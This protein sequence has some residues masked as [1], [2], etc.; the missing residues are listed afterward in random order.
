M[1]RR[2]MV[3][4]KQVRWIIGSFLLSLVLM[5][6]LDIPVSAEE[7]TARTPTENALQRGQEV[8]DKIASITRRAIY[9]LDSDQLMAVIENYLDENPQIKSLRI[10]ENVDQEVL[11]TFYRLDNRPIYNQPIPDVLLKLDV[12]FA[13]VSFEGEQIGTAEIHYADIPSATDTAVKKEDGTLSLS[14]DELTWIADHPVIR[15]HNEKNWAPFNFFEDN[16]PRGLSIDYMN[17]LAA[18]LGLKIVYQTGPSWNDFLQQIR[19]KQ[20]DVMLNIVKTEDRQEYVLFTEPYVKNPNVIVSR[21]DDP[22]KVIDTLK[23]RTVTFPKGFFYEEVLARQYPEIKRMPLED[24][25]ATLKAVALGKADA[26][27][28]EDAVMR[29]AISDNLLTNL[30][31][32]GEADIGNPDFANLRIGVRDDWQLLHSAIEKAMQAVTQ[33]EMSSIQQ[34]WLLKESARVDRSLDS[35]FSLFSLIIGCVV[36]LAVLILLLKLFRRLGYH[37]ESRLLDP[38]NL[39]FVGLVAVA[40]VLAVTF[41]VAWFAMDRMDRRLRTEMGETL[42]AVNRSARESMMMWQKSRMQE[43]KHL[44]RDREFLPLVR[45]LLVLPRDKERI[46]NSSELGQV[47]DF[48]QDYSR[49]M[50]AKGFFIITPDYTSIGSMRDA[51]I[52][53][54]NLI[55][56][57]QPTLLDR[58]FSGTTVF[59]PPTYSDVPLE[60]KS[61]GLVQRT[62]T[63]FFASP[64]R[65]EFG[66]IVAVLTLRFDPSDDLNR[67]TR[68]GNMGGSSETYAFDQ[69][70]RMLTESRLVGQLESVPGYFDGD[71]GLLSMR[72]RDPGGDVTGGYQPSAER[73]QWPLTK[74][75]EDALK[76]HDGL[77]TLGYNDY[78]GIPVFGAWSWLDQAGIG[79]ATEID[80]S[81]ALEPYT[82]MRSLVLGAFAGITLV[83]LLL[84]VLV[85]WL[86]ERTRSRLQVLVD[87]STDELRKVV[88]AVEQSPLCVVITDIVGNIE[89]VNPT[90]ARVTGYQA[91]EVVGKNP[92]VLKSGETSDETYADLWST[93]L[94]GDVWQSEILNKRKNGELYWGS[95]SIAPVTNNA[96]DVTHFVAMTAD[97]TEAKNVEIA[98][99]EEQ[100]QNELILGSA[101]EGIFGLDT[102]GKVTFC[103]SAATSLLGYGPDELIGTFMHDAVHYAH[104]DGSDYRS[105]DCPM[106]AAFRDGVSHQIDDEVLWRKDGTAF[107]VEYSA[108]PIGHGEHPVGAVVVFR[109]IT[110]RKLAED[111]TREAMELAE[112]AT[113]AKSDFLANMSHEIRTP[114]NAII[115]MSHLALQTEL[116]SKQRNYVEKVNRSAESLLGI[117][118]DILDFSK[119]EAGKLDME[120]IEFRLEDVFD[121]LASLVGIKAEEKGLELMF[122]L[123]PELPTALIGDPLRLG[124]ILINL[125]NNAV[126]FTEHGEVVVSV[127]LVEQDEDSAKLHFFVR[128]TGVGLTPEQQGKL[129]QSFSQADSSTTRTYGG[130]GLGLAISKKLVE[131]MAG[132]IWVD[133]E[134]GKGSTFQFVVTAGKQ[135]G[136]ISQRRS[137]K[138]ELGAL[139]VLVVDDNATSR[140]ILTNIL[141]SFGL[142][143]DQAETGQTAL[144]RIEQASAEDPY[145]LV[146]MDWKMPGLDGIETTRAIQSDERLTEI[147]TVVMV[148]AYGR[149]EASQAASGVSISSYLTKPVNPS[150]LLDAIM[151]AMGHAVVGESRTRSR[152]DEAAGDIARLHGARVLLVEDNEINQELALELLT[153]NGINVAMAG[154]G[155]EALEI[156]EQETFDGVLMDCQM[157]VMDGYEATRRIRRDERFGKLPVLAMTANAMAGDREKVLLAGMNDHI[158]KPINVVEMFRTMA[159]WIVPSQPSQAATTRKK[160]ETAIPELDGINTEAGLSRTQGNSKLYLKLLRRVA[161]SQADFVNEFSGAVGNKDWELATRLAHTLKG[162]AGNIGAELLQDASAELEKKALEHQPGTAEL[163]AAGTELQRLLT[164]VRSLDDFTAEKA[165]TSAAPLDREAVDF[166]LVTLAE[167]IADYDTS[168]LETIESNCEVFTAHFLSSQLPLLEK[169]LESYDFEAA[170]DV[171]EKMRDW[172]AK[173]EK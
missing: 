128:D 95:I 117:I 162:V 25:L 158:P 92:S 53:T 123:P 138:T 150:T 57:Q 126:K 115:G 120:A 119:I 163:K 18:K 169:A 114:M 97:I 135:H 153:S 71:S 2:Q 164:S 165:K 4:G 74:M 121:N 72:I 112:E 31:V 94:A 29:Y 116:D 62:A 10:V 82:S 96:G 42:V 108:T 68:V 12:F 26:A 91:D 149:E 147:P 21:V 142:R 122:D 37:A 44:A 89:H 23:G 141:T 170:Q 134:A 106:S 49:E 101:G 24:T 7:D 16:T 5:I 54:P 60:D 154:D 11:L 139:R 35:S 59:I 27:L 40:T 75:A 137:A 52:G 66:Q 43:I 88:Q 140:E 107:P 124:Q 47:R 129:F 65:D 36:F 125:A 86:G 173:D 32:S 109:D 151:R 55:A 13:E 81:E 51:N 22:I 111:I 166:V 130:T 45:Q 34:R 131:L 118:N 14:E 90:F 8:A 9:N 172:L 157:P 83:A 48:Y 146:L 6:G 46:I 3:S 20:L 1:N 79:L 104:A 77:D 41:L 64:L 113:K 102:E 69:Q 39:R 144:A 56:E 67:I 136:E 85:V 93:I 132:E 148:T 143:V 73:S 17:L 100:Q 30:F 167:Q 103:N 33:E 161:E 127:A 28:G 87:K 70:A 98:L 84:T 110:E 58:A 63:M 168:A 160:D 50:G 38:G 19:D 15:V 171:I 80:L 155:K 105:A 99:R 159:R 156:L 152:Q 145:K 76:G 133:S 61:G 78:R